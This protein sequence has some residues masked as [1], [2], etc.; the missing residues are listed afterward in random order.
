MENSQ[1]KYLKAVHKSAPQRQW[2]LMTCSLP[3]S[4]TFVRDTLVLTTL[5]FICYLHTIFRSPT[6]KT[7]WALC[8]PSC[9]SAPCRAACWM[10]LSFLLCRR[11]PQWRRTPNLRGPIGVQATSFF[12][13]ISTA[14]LLHCLPRLTS[15]N[16]PLLWRERQ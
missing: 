1:Q 5:I 12:R 16:H 14:S 10:I 7:E 8:L 13:Q 15:W 6:L 11:N 3:T 4:S 9:R 2:H